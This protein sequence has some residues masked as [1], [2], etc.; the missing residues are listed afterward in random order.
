MF[1]FDDV[2]MSRD[3]GMLHRTNDRD[4]A[5]FSMIYARDSSF[6]VFFCV[7]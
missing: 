7:S 3:T 5:V 1:P 2:I 6:V 4:Y